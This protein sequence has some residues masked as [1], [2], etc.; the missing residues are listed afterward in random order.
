MSKNISLITLTCGEN[1]KLSDECDVS[2][3]SP[4]CERYNHLNWSLLV[5][6]ELYILFFVPSLT[7]TKIY[8]LI[9]IIKSINNYQLNNNAR[10]QKRLT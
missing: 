8:N 3:L 2:N 4:R 9:T 7:S 10:N 5:P 6:H 1:N